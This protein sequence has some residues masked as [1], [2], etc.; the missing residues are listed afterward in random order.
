MIEKL[1]SGGQ[2]GADIAALDVALRLV[3]PT[4]VGVRV[5]GSKDSGESEG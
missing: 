2:I 1:V 5:K 3:S 4:V